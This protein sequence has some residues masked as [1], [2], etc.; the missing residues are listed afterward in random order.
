MFPIKINALMVIVLT[1]NLISYLWFY[2]RGLQQQSPMPCHNTMG[3]GVS[4]PR[5]LVMVTIRNIER[6]NMLMFKCSTLIKLK[7]KIWLLILWRCCDMWCD[8]WIRT[9]YKQVLWLKFMWGYFVDF[10]S[11]LRSI[12]LKSHGLDF[13]TVLYKQSALVTFYDLS[14]EISAELKGKKK[15][16][17]FG[18]AF[19]ITQPLVIWHFALLH[20]GQFWAIS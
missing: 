16:F 13:L 2:L 10:M 17:I 6:G 19:G 3:T 9:N 20:F 15:Q 1:F 12:S 7:I 14:R 5:Q 4:S 11:K 8:M 18:L